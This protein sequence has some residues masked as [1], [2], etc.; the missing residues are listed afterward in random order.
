MTERLTLSLSNS[1]PEASEHTTLYQP[2]PSLGPS[3]L[4]TDSSLMSPLP[5][6][7]S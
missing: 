4:L 2:I 6:S 1:P 7:L 5:G 3:L